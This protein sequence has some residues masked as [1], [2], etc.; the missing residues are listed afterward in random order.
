MS[1]LVPID[2]DEV[3]YCSFAIKRVFD[4]GRHVIIVYRESEDGELKELH[5]GW[6]HDLRTGP[7]GEDYSIFPLS[8]DESDQKYIASISKL[9]A[10]E[11][12]LIPYSIRT[13]DIGID[14]ETGKVSLGAQ[15]CGF[16]CA[17][18]I[19]EVLKAVGF[20]LLN[21]EEWLDDGND[22]WACFIV[23]QLRS[24]GAS[25]EHVAAIEADT[26]GLK[27][28]L[29]EQVVGSSTVEGWPV[30][31]LEASTLADKVLAALP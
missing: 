21:T 10:D 27:R 11:Q 16:T 18:F 31:Y 25:P 26:T 9:I 22:E 24:S 1:D 13:Y 12:P 17:T 23:K 28:V 8:S 19:L 30:G 15:G 5:L 20:Q 7:Y 2:Q 4:G 6:H 3:A 14:R 29:P